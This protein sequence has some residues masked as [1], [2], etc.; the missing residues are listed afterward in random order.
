MQKAKKYNEY[1]FAFSQ[2]D[3]CHLKKSTQEKKIRKLALNP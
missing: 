3:P 1:S 2:N